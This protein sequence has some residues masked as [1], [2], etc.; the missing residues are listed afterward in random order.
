LWL[1]RTDLALKSQTRSQAKHLKAT[2][3]NILQA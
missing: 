1:Q 2:N 3:K